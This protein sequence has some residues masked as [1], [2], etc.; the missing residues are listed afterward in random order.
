[1]LRYGWRACHAT[2]YIIYGSNLIVPGTVP[3]T[4]TRQCFVRRTGLGTIGGPSLP[5]VRRTSYVV[6][7]KPSPE[8][9]LR[10]TATLRRPFSRMVT[11]RALEWFL[12][13]SLVAVNGYR[14]FAR[15]RV[16]V[17]YYDTTVGLSWYI[18]SSTSVAGYNLFQYYAKSCGKTTQRKHDRNFAPATT[19][20]LTSHG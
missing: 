3:S 8:L 16:E 2:S 17:G 4:T 15:S 1:M 14:D 13:V 11:Q 7:T 5:V 10:T 9:V 20:L 12:A 18:R 19:F 6:L